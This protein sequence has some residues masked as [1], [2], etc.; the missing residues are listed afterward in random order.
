VDTEFEPRLVLA[1]QDD[2][3]RLY[4]QVEL[5]VL[6]ERALTSLPLRYRTAVILRDVEQFSTTEAAAALGLPVPT[7]KTRLLRGRLMLR[8]AL[9][10]YF[11][12]GE[13]T[14]ARA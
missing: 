11:V 9:A 13:H 7:L 5:R 6:V 3:E 4:Q 2:P 1:W 14:V 10:P 12:R 8:E